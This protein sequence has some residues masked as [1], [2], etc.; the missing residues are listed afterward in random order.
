[1]A[2]ECN[3]CFREL[4]LQAAHH[5][6]REMN[7]KA[8]IPTLITALAMISTLAITAAECRPIIPSRLAPPAI[9]L[10]TT[11]KVP[12]AS[13]Q[14]KAP[15]QQIQMHVYNYSKFDRTCL[16]WTDRCRICTRAGCSNIGIACQ[17]AEVKCLQ[18]EEV[19][20]TPADH[21]Q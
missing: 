1:M 18:H 17:P 16:R 12:Q 15:G 2:R 20:D 19:K 7:M 10:V 13:D 11:A 9:L 5:S 4:T 6:T 14:T 3:K 8:T 21:A